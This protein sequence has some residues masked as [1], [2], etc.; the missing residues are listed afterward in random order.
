MKSSDRAMLIGLVILGL[1]AAF[2]FMLL[3][4]KREEAAELETQIAAAQTQIDSAQATVAAAEIARADY[5]SNYRTV[6]TLGKAVPSDADTSSLITQFQT[7]AD[8]TKVDFRSLELTQGG[9]APTPAPA[10][11]T[12][13]TTDENADAAAA[14]VT[15]TPTESTAAA[16]PLGA[17]VGPAGLPIMPYSLVFDGDFFEMADFLAALDG[18]VGEGKRTIA[19]GGRLMTI[20]GFNMARPTG[21][22]SGPLQMQL[23]LTTYVT[24]ES[25]GVTAGATPAAPTPTPV[26]APAGTVAP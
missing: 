10:T 5:E 2:W 25:E 6:V 17:S 4:P 1:G 12:E 23:T 8:R 7:L 3:S 24:P 19:V 18:L 21:D 26:A 9:A 20:N 22:A 11:Q 15:A 14:P 13:T 16:L